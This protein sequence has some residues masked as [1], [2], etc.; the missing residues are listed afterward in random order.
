MLN[1]CRLANRGMNYEEYKSK[2]LCSIDMGM[3]FV[4]G[5]S[6]IDSVAGKSKSN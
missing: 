3:C 4:G 2:E 5:N 1:A 6:V